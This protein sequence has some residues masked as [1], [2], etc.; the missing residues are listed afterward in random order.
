MECYIDT[1]TDVLFTYFNDTNNKKSIKCHYVY[2]ITLYQIISHRKCYFK[3][4]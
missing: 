4:I 1:N 2:E 3:N